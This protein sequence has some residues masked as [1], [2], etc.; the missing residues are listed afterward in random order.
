M[1]EIAI[2]SSLE[3]YYN[4]HVEGL[5]KSGGQDGYMRQLVVHFSLCINQEANV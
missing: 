4:I 1:F 5:E 2:M 3:L